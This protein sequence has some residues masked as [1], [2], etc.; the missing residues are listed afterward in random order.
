MFKQVM[1]TFILE[2]LLKEFTFKREH[3]ENTVQLLIEGNTIPF[4]ARYRKEWTGQLDEI[5]LRQIKERY[6]YL[7]DLQ[8]RK[9]VIINSI[10]EQGKL[11][12][13]LR[14][15]IEACLVKHDL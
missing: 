9:A 6:E 8:S 5:Q 12:P 3:I 4:I 2:Q 10:E 13:E 14:K 15:K 11:T 7:I 1:D